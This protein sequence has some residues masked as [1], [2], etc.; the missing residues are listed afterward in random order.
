ML[1]DQ[2]NIKN[3]KIFCKCSSLGG[4]FLDRKVFFFMES[5]RNQKIL[6]FSHV[7]NIFPLTF[8]FYI[9]VKKMP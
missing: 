7:Y 8:C 6:I 2:E 3:L 5:L 4:L 9:C 1:Q